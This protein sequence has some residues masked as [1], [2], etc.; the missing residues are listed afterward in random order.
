MN[1]ATLCLCSWVLVGARLRVGHRPAYGVSAVASSAA[2]SSSADGGSPMSAGST[3]SAASRAHGSSPPWSAPSG[4]SDRTAEPTCTVRA[5]T[6]RPRVRACPRAEA[7][8]TMPVREPFSPCHS[9]VC[10]LPY[11]TTGSPLLMETA[12]FSAM[13]R[14]TLTVSHS[15]R[16]SAQAP[17]TLSKWRGVVAS[18]K[19][20][21]G[22]P[23][24]LTSLGLVAAQ[25]TTVTISPLLLIG[26]PRRGPAGP[27]HSREDLRPGLSLP[28]R[29]AQA[30]DAALSGGVVDAP[31][32]DVDVSSR[33]G[34]S[35]TPPDKAASPA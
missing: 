22:T 5:N 29:P 27:A 23:S 18:R 35:T 32:R 4:S 14:N 13:S 10:S 34:A 11:T 6:E 20:V 7:S 21:N 25:P 30:G 17:W 31:S 2:C 12:T 15:V 16:P 9:S 26:P 1:S 8:T 33:D 3:G 19:L 28:N 24:P